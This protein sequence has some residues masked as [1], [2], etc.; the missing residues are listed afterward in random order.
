MGFKITMTTEACCLVKKWI[1]Y[2]IYAKKDV[3]NWYGKLL[4]EIVKPF[5]DNYRHE[6]D[7]VWFNYYNYP[8]TS[9]EWKEMGRRESF[10]VGERVHFIRFRVRAE[11]KE[12]DRLESELVRLIDKCDIVKVKE[13]CAEDTEGVLSRI[14]G[15][16]RVEMS[17]RFLNICS[18]I[19]LSMLTS[20]N[21]LHLKEGY[22][23]VF[24]HYF[25]NMFTLQESLGRVGDSPHCFIPLKE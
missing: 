9:E 10:K 3:E 11:E 13:K 19:A 21:K 5:A 15:N 23:Y 8:L 22:A 20:D 4:N 12:V 16:N 6:T 17:I 7:C 14:F 18:E 24:L 25:W 1:F 2:R